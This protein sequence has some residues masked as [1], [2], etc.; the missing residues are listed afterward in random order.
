[1]R[2]PDKRSVHVRQASLLS[3]WTSEI[4]MSSID[5]L[6]RRRTPFSAAPSQAW[7]ID[8]AARFGC[9]SRRSAAHHP[10]VGS[11]EA[12]PQALLLLRKRSWRFPMHRVGHFLSATRSG[13]GEPVDGLI[14]H[15][16]R[17][18]HD[19]E[20]SRMATSSD[21]F[22]SALDDNLTGNLNGFNVIGASGAG[23]SRP[24]SFD[25]CRHVL[26]PGSSD[27]RVAI[28]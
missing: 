9:G 13:P 15:S 17:A 6:S 16:H 11:P 27:E 19:H 18:T 22:V 23:R 26:V 2:S 3:R 14:A 5:F 4:T 24:D 1:M 28:F 7:G 21:R 20:G 8:P 12:P 25:A 10:R